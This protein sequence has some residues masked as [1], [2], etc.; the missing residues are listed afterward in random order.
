LETQ[1]LK[2]ARALGCATLAGSGMAV[3]QAADAFDIFTGLTANRERMV[4]SF[5]RF[6]CRPPLAGAA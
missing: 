1:L 5:D 3:F 4:A 2:A 6:D